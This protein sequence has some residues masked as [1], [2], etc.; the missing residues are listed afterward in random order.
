M[1][2]PKCQFENPEGIKFCG[3]CGAKLERVCLSCNSPNPPEFKYCGECGNKLDVVAEKPPTDLSIDEKIEKIQRYLPRG[4]TEKILSQKDRIEGERKHVTVMFCDMAGFTQFAEKLGP[5]ESYSIMDQVYELLIHKVHDYEGTVNEMTGDGIMALFGAPIAVEDAPLRAIRSAYSIHRELSRFSDRLRQEK[6]DIPPLKMRIGIHTGPVV[7]GT[8]GNDL[9]VEFKAVGDTVNLA[10]RM[11]GLAE[12]G[13]TY[14]TAEIFNL[15]EGL[16]RFESLGERDIKGK[17]APIKIYRVI[18]P[19][20]RRTRFDVSAERGLTTFIGRERELELLL[21]GFK[22]VKEGRGQAFSI[23]AEAGIGKSRLLYEFRKAVANE[24]IT[25]LEGK[26]LS[27]S[28]S[29]AYHPVIDVLKSNFDIQEEDA[30]WE[31]TKKVKEGINRIGADETSILPYLLELLSVKDSGIDK[32]PMSPE[33][34]KDRIIDAAKQITLRGAEIRP[35]I[36]AI[37]DLHWIDKGSEEYLKDLLDHIS[38]ARVFLIFTFRPEFV[39]TWGVRSFHNQVNLN[40]LSNRESLMMVSYFLGTKVLDKKLEDFIL[41]KTE[42]IPFFTEEF[43]KSL[44]DMKIIEG[45][46][47]RYR[48]AK[49]IK[50]A[51]IPSTIQDVIMARVDSLSEET[52]SLLQTASVVGREFSHELINRVARLEKR[53][54]VSHLSVLKDAELIYE[55]G[56]FPQSTYVFK[57]ALTQEVIYESLLGKRRKEIHE[58]IS[59]AIEELYFKRLDEYYELLAFHSLQGKDWQ[60]AYKYSREVGRKTFSLSAYEEAQNHF[61]AALEA[62]HKLPRSTDIIEKEIDL[63]FNMRAA[64][65]PQARHQEW[66]KWMRDAET[67]AKQINDDARLSNV[68]NYLSNFH[69]IHGECMKAIELGEKGLDLSRKAGDFACQ[70]G[71]LFHLGFYFHTIGN[72]SRQLQL[73]NNLI[74]LLDKETSFLRYGMANVPAATTRSCL[75]LGMAELGNFKEMDKI[76]QKAIKIAE[77]VKNAFTLVIVYNLIALAYLRQGKLSP[78]FQ[79]LEKSYKQ[80]RQSGVRAQFAYT[81]GNLGYA[82]LLSNEPERALAILEEGADKEHLDAASFWVAHPLIVL[83]EAYRVSG[84]P[85]LANETISR[86]LRLANAREERALEAW[87]MPVIAE[88]NAD[89]DRIDQAIEWYRRGLSKASEFSMLPLT[90]C[91][92][93]GL[94]QLLIKKGHIAEARAAI[95][96]AI[97]LYHSMN[98]S[99]W[100]QQAEDA[101]AKID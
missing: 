82:Y 51:I 5:E 64:L 31:I 74:G 84:K 92:N 58:K 97:D 11:E 63:I 35:L 88:V 32:I 90:A 37:E 17:A 81:M 1:Q 8:V 79:L 78:A 12:P 95:N 4:L 54:L 86:A 24:D 29:V 75:V 46:D 42:G 70:V 60:R 66:G 6:D 52:K 45:E 94:G 91:C 98:I 3:Q 27:Y 13:T 57:H 7:V 80:C 30:D 28:R 100:G 73:H 40:R 56:I 19:S 22:R 26:C 69:W 44:N 53:E 62:L 68:F 47:N 55:R 89:M 87:A 96:S 83:A 25:F 93:F 49:D 72:F 41:S 99:L 39:H 50:E 14:V 38:G 21:D 15:A 65:F 59:V 61:V 2:C 67:L 18:A 76:G 10:S 85:E 20:T 33:D 34:R 16:F 36:I 77:Q 48:I 9:R 43:I 23:V 71:T 101:L